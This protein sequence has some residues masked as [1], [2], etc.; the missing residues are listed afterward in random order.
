M[1]AKR[2]FGRVRQLPSCRWQVRYKGPDGI[3]RP[4]PHTFPTKRDAE[5]WLTKTEA[6]MLDDEW[7]DP[8]LGRIAFL[9]YASAWI[10]ERPD[11][12]PKTVQLYR[13]LLRQ[14]ITPT[15]GTRP[16]ASIRE[17]HIRRWRKSLLDDGASTVTTA[18]AYRLLKAIFN[19]AVDDGLIR[20]NPC[21][22]KGAG[23][24]ASPERPVLTIGQVYA[25]A[26]AI[27]LR[28]RA[29]ILLT[30]FASLRWGE[31]AALRRNDIDL[32][33]G[34]V[35]IGR[36]LTEVNGTLSFAPPKSNAGLRTVPIP[37]VI[38]PDLTWHLHRFTNPAE[39][40]L[41]FTSPDGTPL[42]HSNFNRRVWQPA[43]KAAGLPMIHFHDLRHTGNDL[44]ADA[45][46]SLRELMTRMGHSS[47]RAALIYLHSKDERQQA[48]ADAI[49]K[50]ADRELRP[51]KPSSGTQRARKRRNAS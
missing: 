12:R 42:R 35:R 15:F 23:Q 37:D 16:L 48:I 9:D 1:P 2:R 11:L 14:H 22:I 38:I 34:T 49:S 7:L 30:V 13:Y 25:L 27:S 4:A 21:R 6:D 5:V 41:I 18:K 17:P 40:A 45:G 39:D 43:L 32:D 36:Q 44:A 46:A 3:D 50:R 33:A 47:S 28:Y 31:L 24:E 19:T 26:N 29:M 20:R 8:D 51:K 10:E